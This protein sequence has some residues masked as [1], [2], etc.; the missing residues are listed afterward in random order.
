[1]SQ[2]KAP[3]VKVIDTPQAPAPAPEDPGEIQDKALGRGL[4]LLNLKQSG[5][6]AH[7]DENTKE[8][9]F[10]QT[11]QT[12]EQIASDQRYAEM[13]KMAFDRMKGVVSPET[14]RL[15]GETYNAQRTAGNRELDR[16]ATENMAARG[17]NANDSPALREVGLQ[18]QAMETGLRGAEASSLLDV[19]QRQQLF[20]Q[21]QLEFKKGLEQQTFMNRAMIGQNA[22]NTGLAQMSNRYGITGRSL[23]QVTSGGVASGGFNAGKAGMGMAS[24]ALSG[25]MV[26]SAVPGIGTAVGAGVGALGG[27]LGGFS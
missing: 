24:G 3:K 5:Y 12:P 14:Q 27:L 22:T 6:E 9:T 19:G 16:Y 7:W 23:S 15:V 26:G 18:K 25:A 10:T 21:A 4:N 1:M 20:A 8:Y 2:P 13:E 17:L 11:P